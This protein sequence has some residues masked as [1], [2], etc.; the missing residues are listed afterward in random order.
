MPATVGVAQEAVFSALVVEVVNGT[1]IVVVATAVDELM[2]V[3]WTVTRLA[4]APAIS[5][6]P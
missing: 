1:P 4:D 5:H 6:L 2:Q 3:I